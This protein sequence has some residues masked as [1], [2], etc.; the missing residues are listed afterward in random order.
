MA[1]IGT[2][3]SL[4]SRFLGRIVDFDADDDEWLDIVKDGTRLDFAESSGAVFHRIAPDPVSEGTFAGLEV[5]LAISHH[6]SMA[7]GAEPEFALGFTHLDPIKMAKAAMRIPPRMGPRTHAR[8]SPFW[9]EVSSSRFGSS[10]FV[11]P[12]RYDGPAHDRSRSA[13]VG[14]S[15]RGG[16]LP[17][18]R[19][20]PP[21]PPPSTRTRGSKSPAPVPS[22]RS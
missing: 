5:I 13:P 16:R 4:A 2:R 9:M 22:S 10:G 14:G 20:H 17:P 12:H 11:T 6:A 15:R 18:P 1:F 19:G 3:A 21:R 7:F 8:T